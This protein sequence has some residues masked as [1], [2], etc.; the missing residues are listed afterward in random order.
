M[1][2]GRCLFFGLAFVANLVAHAQ[3]PEPEGYR[4]DDYRA[5]TPATHGRFARW[6]GCLAPFVVALG[7]GTSASLATPDNGITPAFLLKDGVP[8]VTNPT[9]DD[10]FGAVTV[11]GTHITAAELTTLTATAARAR[12]STLPTM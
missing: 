10:S 8:V 4:M 12:F 2:A 1:R 5:P 9:L 6:I 7:F 11:G 3:P